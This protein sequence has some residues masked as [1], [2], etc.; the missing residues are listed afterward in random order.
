MTIFQSQKTTDLQTEFAANASDLD[1]LKPELAALKAKPGSKDAA[2]RAF[3]RKKQTEIAEIE[4]RQVELA[5]ELQAAFDAD[6][7]AANLAKRDQAFDVFA[8]VHSLVP[9]VLAIHAG[10]IDAAFEALVGLLDHRTYAGHKLGHMLTNSVADLAPGSLGQMEHLGPTLA[11]LRGHTSG[12]A[13][14]LASWVR[15][16]VQAADCEAAFNQYYTSTAAPSPSDK[17][18]F[19]KIAALHTVEIGA[20]LKSTLAEN[21]VTPSDVSDLAGESLDPAVQAALDK[22]AS[23]G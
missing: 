19:A 17:T 21:G 5:A 15:R 22:T 3:L 7:S 9:E 16:I 13:K 14:A 2:G 18:N 20:R 11:R 1:I 10:R 12:N 4:A 23:A 8:Q 6:N